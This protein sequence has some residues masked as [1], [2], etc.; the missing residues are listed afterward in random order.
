MQYSSSSSPRTTLIIS[1]PIKI[2]KGFRRHFSRMLSCSSI[3]KK[4]K[5]RGFDY[6]F[7]ATPRDASMLG[8]PQGGSGVSSSA[9][10]RQIAH[11]TCAYGFHCQFK[12]SPMVVPAKQCECGNR[13]HTQCLLLSFMDA[14]TQV[15]SHVNMDQCNLGSCSPQY[16][17]QDVDQDSLAKNTR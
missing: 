8:S 7:S 4:K 13:F 1:Q 16:A 17:G 14:E 2:R 10:Q 11:A 12:D 15:E 5:S 9:L 6:D 3:I